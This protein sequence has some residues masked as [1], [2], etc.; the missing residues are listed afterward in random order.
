MKKFLIIIFLFMLSNK[1]FPDNIYYQKICAEKNCNYYIVN[2]LIED[3][4][5]YPFEQ[6]YKQIGIFHILIKKDGLKT[7]KN[8]IK[9]I[10]EH[11][12]IYYIAGDHIASYNQ[13]YDGT[14]NALKEILKDNFVNFYF[15]SFMQPYNDNG[16]FLTVRTFN[17]VPLYQIEDVENALKEKAKKEK[18]KIQYENKRQIKK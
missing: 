3:R 14:C 6:K 15:S 1:L 4:K 11:L 2:I 13:L 8:N 16:E 18:N 17:I 5:I 12:E 10:K 7:L 9:E